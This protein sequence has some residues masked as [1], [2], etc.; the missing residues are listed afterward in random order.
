MERILF[1]W[2]PQN[3]WV[4]WLRID[5]YGNRQGPIA[6][7]SGIETLSSIVT[8]LSACWVLPGERVRTVSTD[9]PVHSSEKLR[10]ALPYA[11]EDQFAA[12]PERLFYALAAHTK[13]QPVQAA[14][15]EAAWLDEGL[16]RLAGLQ[17]FPDAIIPD[18]LLV[19]WSSGQFC[20]LEWH[21]R[22]FCRFGHALGFTLERD[23][24][25]LLAKTMLQSLE[26]GVESQQP[27]RLWSEAGTDARWLEELGST[28]DHQEVQDGILGIAPLGLIGGLAINLRQGR[29]RMHH[30]WSERTRAWW[31][32]AAALALIV[33]LGLG[34]LLARWI[35]MSSLASQ[36]HAAIVQQ[37]HQ[38]LPGQPLVD[39]Q[40]QLH[41]RLAALRRGPRSSAFLGL[42]GTLARVPLSSVSIRSLNYTG[43]HIEL[44]VRVP[45]MKLLEQ[46]QSNLKRQGGLKVNVNSANQTKKG[47][48]GQ[49]TIGQ[50]GNGDQ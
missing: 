5:R 38:L 6:R 10:A 8:G 17:V 23:A 37:F 50:R 18:Y 1:S 27:V 35:R 49:L 19:P 2:D 48:V 9:L 13:G 31:P 25:R 34:G 28:T 16:A 46:F 30:R 45:N 3:D 24:G 14:V 12:D 4:D 44:Q 33:L 39:V 43:Q 42:M 21:E 20:V 36:E 32:V 11:L 7:Q 26:S 22:I 29:L 40:V 15:A 47:V 41:Q